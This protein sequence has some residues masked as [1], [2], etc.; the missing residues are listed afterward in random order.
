MYPVDH[1]AI[2]L[3]EVKIRVFPCDR[4]PIFDHVLDRMPSKLVIAGDRNAVA[5]T[6]NP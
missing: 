6:D 5:V 2:V 3:K 1:Y 4:A